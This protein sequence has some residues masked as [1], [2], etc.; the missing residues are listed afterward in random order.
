MTILPT[1]LL[2]AAAKARA[3]L[4]ATAGRVARAQLTPG[5]PSG[6]AAL[7]GAARAAI[8]ADA[9]SAALR[10]RLEELRTVAK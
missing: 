8:F 10:A 3:D 9:I 4:T 1:D 7:A 5:A 6:Q 2:D